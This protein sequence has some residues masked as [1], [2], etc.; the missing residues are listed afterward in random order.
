VQSLLCLEN[1]L[2]SVYA[3][4]HAGVSMFPFLGIAIRYALLAIS[5]EAGYQLYRV[6]MRIVG[7]IRGGQ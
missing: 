6:I 7:L 4:Y 1:V 2:A 5:I 3:L